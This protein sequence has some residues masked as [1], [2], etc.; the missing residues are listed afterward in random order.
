MV[1]WMPLSLTD[2]FRFEEIDGAD[3]VNLVRFPSALD[4]FPQGFVSA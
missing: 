2:A 4:I 3:I 1:F